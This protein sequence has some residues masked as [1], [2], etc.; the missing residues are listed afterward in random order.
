MKERIYI[1]D[2]SDGRIRAATLIFGGQEINFLKYWDEKHGNLHGFLK[3]LNPPKNSKIIFLHNSSSAATY[4]GFVKFEKNNMSA[5]ISEHDLGELFSKAGTQFFNRFNEEAKKRLGLD[6]VGIVLA[7]SR[8]FDLKLDNQNFVSPIGIKAK[9]AEINMEQTFL[10]REVLDEISVSLPQTKNIFHIEA[11]VVARDIF[12]SLKDG[13][14]VMCASVLDNATTFFAYDKNPKYFGAVSFPGSQ[15]RGEIAWGSDFV[16][17]ALSEAMGINNEIALKVIDYFKEGKMSRRFSAMFLRI[18]KAASQ[19]FFDGLLKYLKDEKHTFI[20]TAKP[21]LFLG[22]GRNDIT[23]LENKHL[24]KLFNC[25]IKYS[26]ELEGQFLSPIFVLG[27]I[28][29]LKR[30]G[31]NYLK[32]FIDKKL[33]W[34]QPENSI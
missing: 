34:L 29:Y 11:G 26:R 32:G 14:R 31:D 9:L 21:L 19:N 12:D 24:A 2:C 22:K 27:L 10:S 1:V 18:V 30:T 7:S 28:A 33:K 23:V 16:A 13:E 15:A 6:E 4:A 3:K 17:A 25:D 5:A 8:V 20:I